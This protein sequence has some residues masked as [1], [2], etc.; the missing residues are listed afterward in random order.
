MKTLF[1]LSKQDIELARDE[2]LALAKL[3]ISLVDGNLLIIDKKLDTEKL[4]TR[5]AYA[6]KISKLLFYSGW[7]NLLPALEAFHWKKVY[8]KDFRLRIHNL[9]G[10]KLPKEFNEKILS[11][12]VWRGVDKPKVNLKHAKTKIDLFF[13]SKFVYCGLLLHEIK[14][15]FEQ[16]KAH[17]RPSLHPT[18]MH[19][20]LAR[21]MVNLTGIKK[22][23]LVDPF[24]GSGGILIEAGLMGLHPVGYDIDTS[25]LERAKLN[26]EHFKIKAEL[27]QK[28]AAMIKGKVGYVC[29]DLPYGRSSKAAEL[30]KLYSAFLKNLSKRLIKKA[31]IS[32]P[33]FVDYKAIIKKSGF[34]ID[35]EYD[36]YL[37]K[38]LSKRIVVVAKD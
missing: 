32:F 22:G 26:L 34:N 11:G 1:L 36:Y 13:T 16:R 2:A 28:D 10:K 6:T 30:D 9:S 38:S 29:T 21:A 15:K 8:E 14:E 37:H 12:Y 23:R 33:D 19:P 25:M 3:K 7:E 20:K 4:S 5:L 17:K 27:K 18:A 24:C 35:K 31:V